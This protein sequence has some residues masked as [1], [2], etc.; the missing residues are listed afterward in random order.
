MTSGFVCDLRKNAFCE[1][2]VIKKREKEQ[3]IL[4]YP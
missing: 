1:Q 2:A 3:N 4:K